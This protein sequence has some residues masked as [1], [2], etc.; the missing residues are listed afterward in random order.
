DLISYFPNPVKDNLYLKWSLT[1]NKKISFV[2]LHSFS[3]Q[4]INTY[5][6]LSDKQEIMINF[7]GLSQGTYA[8]VLQYSNGTQKSIKIIK[9]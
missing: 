9:Q 5:R 7:Y 3:G 1:D 6:N 8:L 4:V 2:S